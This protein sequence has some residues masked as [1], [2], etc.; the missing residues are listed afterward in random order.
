[1]AEAEQSDLDTELKFVHYN[2]NTFT[3]EYVNEAIL[4]VVENR[5]EEIRKLQDASVMKWLAH[6]SKN[7]A[8]EGIAPLEKKFAEL[9]VAVATNE[10]Q[11]RTE[12]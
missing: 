2:V 7:K 3:E 5:L 4:P 1:M 9:C 6:K 10:K 8:H 12:I 11:I